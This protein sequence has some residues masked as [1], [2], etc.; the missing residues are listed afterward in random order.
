MRSVLRIPRGGFKPAARWSALGYNPR[1]EGLTRG[2][3]LYRILPLSTLYGA[4][5]TQGG[6]GKG[7]RACAI[8]VH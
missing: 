7:G 3:G 1:P 4:W 5:H 8:V 6:E 2:L